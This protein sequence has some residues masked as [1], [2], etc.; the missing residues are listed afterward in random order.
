MKIRIGMI[1]GFALVVFGAGACGGMEDGSRGELGP[2]DPDA[3]VEDPFLAVGWE[4]LADVPVGCNEIGGVTTRVIAS[5]LT[6]ETFVDLFE[7]NAGAGITDP[8][9]IGRYAV[10]VEILDI[11]G[12]LLAA[13]A[14]RAVELTRRGTLVPVDFRFPVDG[15]FF[16]A[17]WTMISPRGRTYLACAEVGAERVSVLATNADTGEGYDFLFACDSGAGF[18]GKLPLGEY[19]VVVA[20]LGADDEVLASASPLAARVAWGNE[21]VDLGNF[22]FG[23]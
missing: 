23:I 17:T 16:A 9:P 10:V 15:G 11:G 20:L 13:S 3:T 21:L 5:K 7:C 1:I 18:T 19:T 12:A 8:L 6:G 14:P 22:E 2:T 4:L